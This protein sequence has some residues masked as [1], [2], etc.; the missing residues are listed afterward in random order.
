MV[1]GHC[2]SS[3]NPVLVVIYAFHMPLFFIVS[4]MLYADKW[5]EKVIL[6]IQ[7]ICIRLLVPYVFYETLFTLFIA[8]LQRSQNLFGNIW[9]RWI[10]AVL[11]LIGVTVTW[12]LPCQLFVVIFSALIMKVTHIRKYKT[13]AIIFLFIFAIGLFIPVYNRYLIVLWR[14]FIGMG[15]FAVGYYGKSLFSKKANVI[16][17]IVSLGIFVFLAYWNGM[18]SLVDMRFSDPILYVINGILGSYVLYQ[19]CLLM[20]TNRIADLFNY[21]GKNT[22]VILCTH[23]FVVEIIRLLDYKLFNNILSRLGIYEGFVFGMLVLA[24]M[25]AVIPICNKYFWWLFGYSRSS[26]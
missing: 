24:I 21:L 1:F 11:P 26:K 9:D 19:V 5:Q 10:S 23:M 18:V 8:I 17:T 3:E 7:K 20:K 2:Y 25:C 16:I 14:V 4:G 6:N 15:F 22:A 12:F 13:G